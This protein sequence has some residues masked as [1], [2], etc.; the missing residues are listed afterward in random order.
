ML[1]EKELIDSAFTI[2][3]GLLEKSENATGEAINLLMHKY[4]IDENLAGEAVSIAL[5]QWSDIYDV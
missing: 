3:G 5:E 1:S 4:G 2:L